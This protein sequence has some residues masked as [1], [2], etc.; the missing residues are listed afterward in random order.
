M[1]QLT[2]Q[3]LKGGVSAF[4]TTILSTIQE[5]FQS[6]K[7]WQEIEKKAYPP[8]PSIEKKKKKPKDK[9][10]RHPGPAKVQVQPDGSVEGAEKEKINVGESTAEALEKLDVKE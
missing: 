8:P 5:D 9:G 4:L 7:E 6:N 2:P 3:L 10:T 1:K